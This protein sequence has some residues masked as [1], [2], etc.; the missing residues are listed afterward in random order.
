MSLYRRD[1]LIS[2]TRRQALLLSLGGSVVAQV[3]D[4]ARAPQGKTRSQRRP[5][6]AP[7]QDSLVRWSPR[8]VFNG[9]PVLFESKITFKTLEPG[10]VKRSNSDPIVTHSA[11][12]LG[13]T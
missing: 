2:M 1:I 12:L 13:S 5:T 8:P 9:A 3:S 7:L 6:A 10:S 11:P 4:P